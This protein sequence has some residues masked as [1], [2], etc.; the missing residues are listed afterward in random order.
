MKKTIIFKAVDTVTMSVETMYK[1]YN[2]GTEYTKEQL[3]FMYP[4]LFLQKGKWYESMIHGYKFLFEGDYG[5]FVASGVNNKGEWLHKKFGIHVEGGFR[6]LNGLGVQMDC[7]FRELSDVEVFDLLKDVAVCKGLITNDD[8]V[9]YNPQNNAFREVTRNEQLF[10]VEGWKVRNN[11]PLKWY[12]NRYG[13]VMFFLTESD[14]FG[15]G[16]L[17]KDIN[18]VTPRGGY[19]INDEF[20]Q[21]KLAEDKKVRHLLM[22]RA[23]NLYPRHCTVVQSSQEKQQSIGM[24]GDIAFSGYK[25]NIN[26][27]ADK[28]F[29]VTLFNS[30]NGEWA[31]ICNIT[32]K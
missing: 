25:Y 2:T 28:D 6:E 13:S 7:E 1:L 30:N 8:Y 4:N 9:A 27:N 10:S 23:T 32:T 21:W 15:F 12:E 26:S 17:K 20:Q 14:A 31:K 22:S 11:A 18:W 19:D 5:N 24:V 16:S 3:G 29:S